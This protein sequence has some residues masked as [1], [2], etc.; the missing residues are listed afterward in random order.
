MLKHLFAQVQGNIAESLLN[1]PLSY[2]NNSNPIVKERLDVKLINVPPTKEIVA[3]SIRD[4]NAK[5]LGKLIIIF[6]T[7]VRTGNVSS[8]ELKKKF[9]CKSCQKEYICESDLAEYNRFITPV[10][11]EGMVEK[12]KPENYSI[13]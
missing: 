11:C 7:V 1:E 12:K 13:T 3:E 9:V 2:S 10:A 6:G 4:L 8:R 5:H